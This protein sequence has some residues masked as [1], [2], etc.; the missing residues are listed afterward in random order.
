[1]SSMKIRHDFAAGEDV[2]AGSQTHHGNLGSARDEA[3]SLHKQNQ[4]ALG[5][6]VA[7]SEQV[8]TIAKMQ[9]ERDST[10]IDSAT[11]MLSG[12]Q[13]SQDIQQAASQQAIKYFGNN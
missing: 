8:A 9:Y 11:K 12:N 13:K 4:A 7:G 1:M 3:S 5:T 2:I 6:D 10:S